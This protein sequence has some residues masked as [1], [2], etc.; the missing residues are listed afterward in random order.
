MG[1]RN[2]RVE[3]IQ[4]TS[5]VARWETDTPA[6]T[7]LAIGRL[8]EDGS[9]ELNELPPIGDIGLFHEYPIYDL[10]PSTTYRVFAKSFD[11]NIQDYMACDDGSSPAEFETADEY[12]AGVDK[13]SVSVENK[14]I[15][16]NET[17]KITVTAT[18]E[19][20]IPASGKDLIFK[21]TNG[22]PGGRERGSFEPLNPKTD[23]SGK[24]VVT[25]TPLH[26]GKAHIEIKVEDKIAQTEILVKP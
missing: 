10:E 6:T 8:E 16:L 12:T 24:A 11:E 18:L 25:F 2:F 26:L 22:T 14:E 4:A 13:I 21:I 20:G 15:K 23:S 19:N 7:E 17:S 3:E 9:C 1:I 5:A